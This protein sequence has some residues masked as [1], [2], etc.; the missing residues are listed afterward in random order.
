MSRFEPEL[1]Q[2]IF[3]NTP[4]QEYSVPDWL[5]ALLMGL[6]AEIERVEWNNTQE[7]VDNPFS[8]TGA[9]YKTDKF[10]VKAYCWCDGERHENGCPPNFLYKPTGFI[11]NWYKH[12]GRGAS[13][14]RKITPKEATKMFDDCLKSVR[15][16]EKNL[17]D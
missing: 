8:N 9:E 2:M 1:G 7:V 5:E 17:Y 16:A 4:M 12:L 6:W 14:N 3:T 11:V 15:K 13:M 10:E